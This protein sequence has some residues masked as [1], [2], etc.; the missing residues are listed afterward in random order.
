[1]LTVNKKLAR[2]KADNLVGRHSAVR[3]ANPEKLWC[4]CPA[5]TLKVLRIFE[6]DSF[7]P[8]A[9]ILK[10][11]W[12]EFHKGFAL[13]RA[14]LVWCLTNSQYNSQRHSGRVG[15]SSREPESRKIKYFWIP[16]FAGMTVGET[17]DFFCEL[18]RRDT[19]KIGKKLPIEEPFPRRTTP[20]D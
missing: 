20:T 9:V 10:K 19:S 11:F 1:M 3:A 17:T 12:Q 7:G 5:E 2:A 6:L 18:L 4:L 14:R 8:D 16:A 15:D 13:I